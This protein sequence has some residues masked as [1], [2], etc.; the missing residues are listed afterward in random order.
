MTD[1]ASL[2][3]FSSTPDRD[4][5]GDDATTDRDSS[6][7]ATEVSDA[8]DG[9]TVVDTDGAETAADSQTVSTYAW[10]E[11]TCTRC[12]RATDRVWRDDGAFVCP[13]CKSW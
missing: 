11:Y 4:D 2:S 7:T 5:G 12:D 10:G 8:D 13:A 6:T 9:P 3:D 1:D